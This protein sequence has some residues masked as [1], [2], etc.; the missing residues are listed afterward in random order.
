M[1]VGGAVQSS[2]TT[3]PTENPPPPHPRQHKPYVD[4]RPQS[5]RPLEDMRGSEPTYQVIPPIGPRPRIV[6]STSKNTA[7]SR[8]VTKLGKDELLAQSW[9]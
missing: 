6:P 9:F 5:S 3:R 1:G 4:A 2:R 8:K 7:W